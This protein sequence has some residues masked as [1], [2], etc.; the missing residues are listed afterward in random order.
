[1]KDPGNANQMEIYPL[2]IPPQ[3]APGARFKVPR[4][5]IGGFV[6]AR[7][8]AQADF[9]FKVRGSDLRCDLKITNQR[10]TLGGVES[11]R[12]LTGNYL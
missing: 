3:T 10:A 11:V 7:V 12:G 5:D 9:R 8:K 1:M 2:V 6:V 4:A